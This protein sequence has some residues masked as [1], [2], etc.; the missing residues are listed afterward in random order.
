MVTR[1][2]DVARAF[3]AVAILLA[4]IGVI[5]YLVEPSEPITGH[6]V[7]QG[8][9]VWLFVLILIA[10]L[11]ASVVGAALAITHG[12]ESWILFVAGY[13]LLA[14]MVGALLGRFRQVAKGVGIALIPIGFWS[15]V[16]LLAT[17]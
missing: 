15:I 9:A 4:G 5:G 1:W 3:G 17:R 7:L 8:L 2:T 12:W 13:T 6:L 14:L 11:G 10:G 16:V